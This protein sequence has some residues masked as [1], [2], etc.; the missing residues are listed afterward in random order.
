MSDNK[1]VKSILDAATITGL[2]AGIGWIGRKIIKEDL[3]QRQ[4]DELRQVHSR[5]GGQ[6]RAE[7]I[8]GGSED[9]PNQC[10]NPVYT[11]NGDDRYHGWR[12]HSQCGHIHRRQLSRKSP[13]CDSGQAA[14][15]EKKRHDLALE[16]YQRDYAQYQ[17][18]RTQLLD[19]VAGHD[20]EKNQ[21]FHDFQNTDQALALYNQTHRA[22]VALPQEP[23]FSDY[24]K[25]SPQQ[26]NGELLFIGASTL[27]LGYAAF[28]FL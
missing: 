2:V 4:S 23:K 26:K 22:K 24:Y 10:V 19:W 7:E 5:H 8:P 14:L 20:R 12:G 6:H 21:A 15:D 13:V 11:H 16:K 25:P 27:A 28:R 3:T 18:D 9:T 17:Q 1:L